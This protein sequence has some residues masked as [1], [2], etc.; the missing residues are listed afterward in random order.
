MLNSVIHYVA[1]SHP[2]IIPLLAGRARW[3]AEATRPQAYKSQEFFLAA[4]IRMVRNVYYGI[5]GGDFIDVMANL[6]SGQITDAYQQAW[7]DDGGYLPVPPYLDQAIQNDVLIQ[8]DYVDRYY[9][10]I[11]DARVDKTPLEPLLARAQLWANQWNASY[12]NALLVMRA[13]NGGNLVWVE[14][15]TKDKCQTCLSLN[16]I[17]ASAADWIASGYQPQGGMLDCGGWNCQCALEPTD[18]RRSRN[19]RQRLGVA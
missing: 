6:I 15:D 3:V 11:V 2:D 7:M 19:F 8:Y 9:R 16:G 4:I 13:E 12:N 14:G 5:L 10:D 18:Q 1:K 17:V